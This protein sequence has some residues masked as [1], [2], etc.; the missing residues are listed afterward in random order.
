M[1]ILKT[2]IQF[3]HA[4]VLL[5]FLLPAQS[6]AKDW[7]YEIEPYL[8]FVSIE[9]DASVGRVTG[10]AVDVDFDQNLE[11]AAMLHFE[12]YHKKGWGLSLDYGFMDLGADITGPLGGATNVSVRQGILEALAVYRNKLSDGHLDYLV[13][14]R[15]W[16]NDIDVTVNPAILPG[17]VT[18]N[19]EE[20][21]VDVL[22]ASVG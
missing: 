22:L 11:L 19:I 7:A 12:A 18:T 8:M 20:D 21:W 2:T 10:V 14:I 1:K 13:G 16:D 17:T 4:C 15:W 5:C 3:I 9:G 6:Y